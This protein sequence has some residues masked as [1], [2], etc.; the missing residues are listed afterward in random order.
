MKTI[1]TTIIL[2]VLSTQAFAGVLDTDWKP[3]SDNAVI[4]CENHDGI[5]EFSAMAIDGDVSSIL[6]NDEHRVYL[7]FYESPEAGELGV[8]HDGEGY[9]S[10]SSV[11]ISLKGMI[12]ISVSYETSKLVKN[13]YGKEVIEA[14]EKFYEYF[15]IDCGISFIN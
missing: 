1:L 12:D 8:W 15:S 13:W 14:E 10:G 7:N 2:T 6:V 3:A 9:L 5:T 11:Y 4:T